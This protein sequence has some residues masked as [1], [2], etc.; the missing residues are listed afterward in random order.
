MGCRIYDYLRL[1][2]RFHLGHSWITQEHSRNGGVKN[3]LSSNS[4]SNRWLRSLYGYAG[5]NRR[6][7]FAKFYVLWRLWKNVDCQ[8]KRL[9][10][11]RQIYHTR[12]CSPQWQSDLSQRR[13]QANRSKHLLRDKYS[14]IHLKWILYRGRTRL[15]VW[16]YWS[17]LATKRF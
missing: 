7:S 3:R 1:Q 16:D 4:S 6:L 5:A 13:M 8:R 14:C 17:N 2:R 9:L 15:N 10:T 12:V 11:I